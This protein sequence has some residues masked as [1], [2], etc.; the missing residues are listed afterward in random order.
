M[1]NL[2]IDI[3]TKYDQS[4]QG[5]QKITD[6]YKKMGKQ[7]IETSNEGKVAD[8]VQQKYIASLN[9][10]LLGLENET[11]ALAASK[12]QIK[13][14]T[15]ERAKMT[16]SLG[17]NAELV[18]K[19]SDAI[20]K[21][22]KNMKELE[23]ESKKVAKGGMDEFGRSSGNAATKLLSVAKNILKFQLLMGPIT[24]AIRG[25]KNTLSDSVK[26]AAEAE[27]IYSKLSTVFAGLEDSAK[28]AA[29]AISSQ[30]GVATTTAASALSTV[31]DL[32]QA[33][34]MGTS[35]SLTTAS[36]WVSQFQDII[37]FKDLNM[38][39]EEFAQTFMSGAAGNLRNFR[40]FGSIVKE[41]QVQAVLA[42][43]GLDKL[44]GSELEL[45]KMT[46]RATLA[47]E[48][49]QNAMGATEREWE[50][51]LSVNRRLTEAW[52]EYK[53]NLGTSIN[54]VLRPAKNWL[55][56]I[57]DY[58]NDV[59]RAL[60][61]IN[62]GEFTVK[63]EQESTDDFIKR[64]R[65]VYQS[66]PRT[67]KYMEQEEMSFWDRAIEALSLAG[68]ATAQQVYAEPLSAKQLR[69]IMLSTGAT[70]EQLIE[71]A[72][73]GVSDAQAEAAERLVKEYWDLQEAVTEAR[74]T[75]LSSAEA[76]D[77][78]TE[79]LANLGHVS[80]R[81]TNLAS[82]G[83]G[84]NEYN[85]EDI[86]QT[87][88]QTAKGQVSAI[89]K[90][91]ISQV[92]GFDVGTFTS[93]FDKAFG[94]GSATDAYTAWM[95]EIESLYTILYNREVQFGD[96]GQDTLD[97]VIDEWGRVN[98]LLQQYNDGLDEA[99]AKE[100]ALTT[101]QNVANDYRSQ[102]NN[103][104]KSTYE[105]T[106]GDLLSKRDN[107]LDGAEANLYETAA[108]DYKKFTAK[109]LID[110][111]SGLA[112]AADIAKIGM[113]ENEKALYD[114]EQKYKEASE[115]TALTTEDQISLRENYEAERDS[116]I[117]F[118][119]QTDAAAKA[120]AQLAVWEQ[121]ANRALN[122][123]GT[124]GSVVQQFTDG[125]GDIWS[126]I[127]NA[128]LTIM[129]NTEGWADI[130]AT[131]DQIFEMFEP[132][133]DGLIN[134]ILSLPWEDIIYMLKVIATV[135]V[136]IM[137]IIRG[138]QEVFKWLW[139]NIKVA[140][141]NVKEAILHPITGG[142]Q[143]SFR[144]FDNLKQTIID[145]AEDVK[146]EYERIWA[147]NEKIERNTRKDDVLK[148][149]KELYA[150]GVI[151]E[152]QFYAG[153]RVIQKDKVFDPVPAG[154]PKYLSSPTQTSSVI[155]YG[156]VTLQFNGDNIDEL[157]SWLLDFFNGN[158]IAYNTA[159]GG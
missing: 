3:V 96:V 59:A 42:S 141:N 93:D 64:V 113:T 67:V 102:L 106:Y 73:G 40:T 156:G 35:E 139:D 36:S 138:I 74:N 115:S 11:N 118:Q 28:A 78:F 100:T 72:E 92:Q 6:S 112:H 19:L 13:L 68:G 108:D 14:L 143:R 18:K 130:A 159:I 25:F 43:K 22:T 76:Y 49:Q 128:L 21:E 132:V 82:I 119:K 91:L 55:T 33:Q 75:I 62:G 99:K 8:E 129:E 30:L 32:L 121:T 17:S 110:S 124:L 83:E 31:G 133:V 147:V 95:K 140:L 9:A 26:V 39:L 79:S 131:L 157:K 105:I 10:A 66:A 4:L 65:A 70:K 149:L 53:E 111:F 104:G 85:H 37:A 5:A 148:T 47:L 54:Q 125:E 58:S 23:A 61:E 107:A 1:A 24:G 117:E 57:L 103:Y 87:F 77:N 63:V 81:T 71:A 126:D 45:A 134:L 80:I 34:G 20:E 109:G 154:S 15:Q 135:I 50:T 56:E 97:T 101:A 152:D 52:K 123:T 145:V 90:S 150:A 146:E 48:Q 2:T 137:G 122:S 44:T 86:M 120:A 142:D 144:S 151:N 27:Q 60:K 7:L 29:S 41:S 116:L 94:T 51:T 84:I 38:S 46:T 69:D 16:V 88:G 153:A 114:L 127:V 158:G 89:L 136:T 12:A 98:R 155:S